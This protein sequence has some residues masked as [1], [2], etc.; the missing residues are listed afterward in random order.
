MCWKITLLNDKWHKNLYFFFHLRWT[1]I[2]I[3]RKYKRTSSASWRKRWK[4]NTFQSFGKKTAVMT[5][6]TV[7][8]CR[9][10]RDNPRWWPTPRHHARTVTCPTTITKIK[11][12]LCVMMYETCTL[13]LDRILKIM[14]YNK[15]LPY[16]IIIS[17]LRNIQYSNTCYVTSL[18]EFNYIHR[19]LNWICKYYGGKCISILINNKCIFIC[20]RT[21]IIIV[22]IIIISHTYFCAYKFGLLNL[23]KI[24]L[25]IY[26][27]HIMLMLKKCFL[28]KLKK[29]RLFE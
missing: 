9:I 5:S 19:M 7:L 18:I 16:I 2:P 3:R 20:L 8:S 1:A 15:R 21:I 14:Y 25:I 28:Q 29:I 26:F 17:V 23:L 13:K 10:W 6:T 24:Y 4:V 11:G 12:K 22:R 27:K